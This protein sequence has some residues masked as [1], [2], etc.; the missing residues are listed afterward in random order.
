[1]GEHTR[2]RVWL[3]APSQPASARV[4]Q[5]VKYPHAFMP[6]GF[7]ARARKTAPEGGCAP[8]S[9][10]GARTPC[11]SQARRLRYVGAARRAPLAPGR[12]RPVLLPH[13]S[14]MLLDRPTTLLGPSAT[15]LGRSAMMLDRPVTFLGR[16][17]RGRTMEKCC[18]TLTKGCRLS[19]V[20]SRTPGECCR[21]MGK[22]CRTLG[23]R[24]R[25]KTI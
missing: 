25:A 1:M 8:H 22:R 7:S 18:R 11:H 5:V 15:H 13:R 2:P 3:A 24:C 14:A 21:S 19:G 10:A 17:A 6:P 12:F 23:K 16:S 9:L 4:P 20:W